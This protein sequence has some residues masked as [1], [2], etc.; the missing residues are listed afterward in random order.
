M[1]QEGHEDARQ[2]KTIEVL[3]EYDGYEQQGIGEAVR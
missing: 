3:F 1:V 2:W